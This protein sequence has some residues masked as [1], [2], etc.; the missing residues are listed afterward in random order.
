MGK[1][2]RLLNVKKKIL[3]SNESI[4]LKDIIDEN[5]LKEEALAL[6]VLLTENDFVNIIQIARLKTLIKTSTFTNVSSSEELDF[7]TFQLDIATIF[8]EKS[9]T[10]EN[11]RIKIEKLHDEIVTKTEKYI[12]EKDSASTAVVIEELF[13]LKSEIKRVNLDKRRIEKSIGRYEDAAMNS[14]FFLKKITSSIL[15]GNVLFKKPDEI[16]KKI[17]VEFWNIDENN[18]VSWKVITPLESV[19]DL[20]EQ[21]QKRLLRLQKE[22]QKNV[23]KI[24]RKLKK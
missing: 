9:N 15:Q 20:N 22:E 24:K 6:K 23:K 21:L 11:A 12:L 10:L 14:C 5:A 2:G 16:D 7:T 19:I 4:V 1:L 8:P 18:G 3:T 13:N 17:S